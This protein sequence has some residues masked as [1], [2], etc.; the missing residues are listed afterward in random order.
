MSEFFTS[1][2]PT[3]APKTMRRAR[4]RSQ[5]RIAA[6]RAA[7]WL[8]VCTGICAFFFQ[9]TFAFADFWYASRSCSSVSLQVSLAQL[10]CTWAE[11]TRGSVDMPLGSPHSEADVGSTHPS[12][13]KW[14]CTRPV[15]RKRRELAS[16]RRLTAASTCKLPHPDP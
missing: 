14:C 8:V 3:S 9:L 12:V 7:V 10:A 5:G 13:R 15:A 4:P 6:G 11:A 2:S 1:T 16:S